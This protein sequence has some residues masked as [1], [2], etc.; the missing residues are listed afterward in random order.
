MGPIVQQLLRSQI[1]FLPLL[2]VA[3]HLG[4]SGV[5][6]NAPVELQAYSNSLGRMAF[7]IATAGLGIYLCRVFWLRQGGQWLNPQTGGWRE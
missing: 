5:S 1:L 6:P 3:L 4:F 2:Y 7:M